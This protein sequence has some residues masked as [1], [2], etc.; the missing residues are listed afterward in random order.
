M[1]SLSIVG[2][3]VLTSGCAVDTTGTDDET[4]TTTQYVSAG[5]FDGG[6]YDVRGKLDEAFAASGHAGI[7]SL[8]L[9][10]S[11]T[12]K[13]G[14]VHDCVWTFAG[15]AHAVDGANATI[16]TSQP[17]YECHVQPKTTL[18]KFDAQMSASNDPLHETLLGTT[19]TFDA[20]LSDC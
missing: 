3:V 15:E 6:F 20:V 9:E 13:I 7:T 19:T 18:A 14:N 5:D 1:R 8:H 11:V 17:W 12:S 10:C 16:A 2:L 4:S